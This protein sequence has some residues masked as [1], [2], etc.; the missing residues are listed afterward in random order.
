MRMLTLL[1]YLYINLS[2]ANI[3]TEEKGTFHLEM[4]K[5][6]FFSHQ[7][8]KIVSKNLPYPQ[9][10]SQKCAY[11]KKKNKQPTTKQIVTIKEK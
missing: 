1:R 6:A 7:C 3:D 10:L 4:F 2:T 5:N 8:S 9:F 11:G